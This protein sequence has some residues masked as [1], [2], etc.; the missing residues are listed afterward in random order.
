MPLDWVLIGRAGAKIREERGPSHLQML[1][2]AQGNAAWGEARL[3]KSPGGS[4]AEAA[5]AVLWVNCVMLCQQGG[6]LGGT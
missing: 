4:D 6:G 5:S 3:G 2:R 1:C